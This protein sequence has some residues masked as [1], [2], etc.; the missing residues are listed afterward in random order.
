MPSVFLQ[1]KAEKITRSL[2]NFQLLT[3][4]NS[5]NAGYFSFSPNNFGQVQT[6]MN[7]GYNFTNGFYTKKKLELM[8]TG[9][10]IF[11]AKT[12]NKF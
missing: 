6:I 10:L 2:K 1:V 4:K 12:S 8:K 9:V 3:V 5:E 11:L 7:N